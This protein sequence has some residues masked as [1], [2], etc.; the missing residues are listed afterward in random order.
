MLLPGWKSDPIDGLNVEWFTPSLKPRFAILFLHPFGGE[1]P[2]IN[3]SY[4]EAFRRTGVAVCAPFGGTSWW[5]DRICPDFS[6][7]ITSERFLLD[8]ILP[9]MLAKWALSPHAIA[10]AGI[11]MGGQGAVRL[12][13]K[14]PDQ[15]PIVASVAGAFDYY[16]WHGQ[17]TYL[18]T[19]YRSREACRQDTAIL[20]LH[21]SNYPSHI[22]LACD[23]VDQWFRGNDRLHE[24]LKAIGIPHDAN[25]VTTLGGHCWTY[26]D[27]MAEPTVEWCH[28]ALEKESRRLI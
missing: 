5:A 23:P 6:S 24:K 15:F 25:F 13:F 2:S 7:S 20:H 10:V 27:A 9:A 3:Y 14:Y 1:M 17:G 12:G 26:F 11:S 16:E 19:I 28:K 21:P 18:D 4:T 22:H 8:R